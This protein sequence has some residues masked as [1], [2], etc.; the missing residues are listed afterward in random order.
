MR[1]HPM[2]LTLRLPDAILVSL[3]RFVGLMGDAACTR[4]DLIRLSMGGVNVVKIERAM[5]K[6]RS[7][8]DPAWR[9]PF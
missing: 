9:Q 8:P 7:V 4:A 1:H 3:E 2:G 6:S 5:A